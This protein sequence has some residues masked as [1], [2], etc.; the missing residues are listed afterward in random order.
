MGGDVEGHASAYVSIRQRR[1]ISKPVYDIREQAPKPLYRRNLK[2]YARSGLHRP[3]SARRSSKAELTLYTRRQ[4]K[5]Y[6]TIHY[7]TRSGLH[8]RPSARRRAQRW[9]GT[10]RYSLYLLYWYK[11]T[12]TDAAHAQMAF[13][14]CAANSV[15]HVQVLDL[16]A[17][18]VQWYKY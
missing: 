7:S 3:P 10:R 9:S 6:T 17:L 16:L 4:L 15:M 14:A 13:P 5:L 12:N 8:R 2:L 18:L 11:S 1:S